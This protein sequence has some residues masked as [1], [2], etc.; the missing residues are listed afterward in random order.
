MFKRGIIQLSALIKPMSV[1]LLIGINL[2]L[3]IYMWF[4]WPQPISEKA[5]ETEAPIQETY[6][7]QVFDY[8][9]PQTLEFAGE[10]IPL[11]N[12]V[13]R[14]RL[15]QALSRLTYRHAF[16]SGNYKR[17]YRWFPEIE[18]ILQ[19]ND[20]PDDLKYLAVI[21]SN[22][23]NAISVK[24]ATGFWQF[25]PATGQEYGLEVNRY[26]DERYHPLKSTKAACA[27][28]KDAYRIFQSWTLAS[29]S[30]NMG[31]RG[32]QNR[33]KQQKVNSYF[34][35]YLNQE[36]SAYVYYALATKCIFENPQ[37]YGYII[38]DSSR[39]A[40]IDFEEL[41]IQQAIPDLIQFAKSKGISYF[42]LKE[43]N[44]WLRTYSLPQNASAK[45]YQILIP[46]FAL[47]PKSPRDTQ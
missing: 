23:Q 46:K 5:S 31:M 37:A 19:E 6:L 30:Y 25:M 12:P 26:V 47:K 15:D 36:T 21:E 43:Y 1:P 18:K 29:A 13:V 10:K 32:L 39:Y 14:E 3:L 41:S 34:D 35:L 28:F 33:L 20:I 24:G 2:A 7:Y 4:F 22:L 11:D 17:A 44:P 45:E 40:P 42:L 9:L 38:P 8:P 16:T 27:Y